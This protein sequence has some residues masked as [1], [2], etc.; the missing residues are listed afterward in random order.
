MF[1]RSFPYA[2]PLV[3]CAATML[4][5]SA[6]AAAQSTEGT[7]PAVSHQQIVSANPFGLMLGWWNVEFERKLT[8]SST[9]GANTSFL[10]LKGIDYAS[11]NALYRYYPQRAALTGKIGRAHV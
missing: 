5:A 2:L 10:T 11:V 7:K 6:P 4:L 9:W 8:P 3:A 1:S